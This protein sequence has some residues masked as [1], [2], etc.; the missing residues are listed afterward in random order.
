MYEPVQEVDIP[1][2]T[3]VGST[4]EQASVTWGK[5]HSA[6]AGDLTPGSSFDGWASGPALGAAEQGWSAFMT[7]LKGELHTYAA[8]LTQSAK[9]YQAAD[10]AAAQRAGGAYGGGPR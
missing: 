10:Q 7:R 9:D 8:G 5:A 3:R 4:A 1:G 2:L 6:H